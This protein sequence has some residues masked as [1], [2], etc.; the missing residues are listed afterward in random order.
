MLESDAMALLS[1]TSVTSV[2]SLLSIAGASAMASA[3]SISAMIWALPSVT[4]VSLP[5]EFPSDSKTWAVSASAA[6][7]LV[8][9]STAFL[10][11][12]AL[13]SSAFI[14]SCDFRQR[15]SSCRA[16]SHWLASTAPGNCVS[17]CAIVAS[18]SAQSSWRRL[19]SSR[20]KSAVSAPGLSMS[21]AIFNQNSA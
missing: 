20:P 7:A 8:S 15:V 11:A 13:A 14:S 2:S 18:A 10:S 19:I 17:S 4:A 3:A 6:T 9:A 12:W 5:L 21:A 1:W 16:C